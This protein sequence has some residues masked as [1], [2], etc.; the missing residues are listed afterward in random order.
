[1]PDDLQSDI[2]ATAE[3]IAADSEI[4]RGIE[5]EK[6]TLDATDPRTLELATQAEALAHGIASKTS[7]ERELVAEANG[8]DPATST[9]DEPEG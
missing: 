6:A 1:M 9:G 8:G 2:T 5:K 7:A 4:L 3:D